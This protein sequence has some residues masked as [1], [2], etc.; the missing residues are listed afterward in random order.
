[1]KDKVHLVGQISFYCVKILDQI[2][3]FAH[4]VLIKKL[5]HVIFRLFTA[6]KKVRGLSKG[7]NVG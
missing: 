4:K 5:I 1:M 3:D 7:M 2:Y 6:V